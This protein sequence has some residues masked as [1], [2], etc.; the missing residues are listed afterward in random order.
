MLSTDSKLG[1]ATGD[2]FTGFV[3]AAVRRYL[4]YVP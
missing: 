4:L 1:N 3:A 2:M